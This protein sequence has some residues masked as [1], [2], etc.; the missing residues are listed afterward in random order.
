M[1]KLTRPHE[2]FSGI[3]YGDSRI[4]ARVEQVVEDMTNNPGKAIFSASGSRSQAKGG[5][6]LLANPKF[7]LDKLQEGANQKSIETMS[8][9]SVVLLVQDTMDVNYNTHKKTIGLGY[10]SEKA[11]GVKVHTCLAMS[12]NGVPIGVM[13]QDCFTR[14]TAKNEMGQ[15]EKAARPIEEKES[16]RWL[17]SMRKTTS[18]IPENITAITICDRECDFYEFY[19]EAENIDEKFII[20]I[21]NNRVTESGREV[22][23]VLENTPVYGTVGVNI[24]RD[25]RR[26]IP[27]RTAEMEVTFATVDLKKPAIRKETHISDL[28]TFNV[29]RIVEKNPSKNVQPIEWFLATNLS[30][31]TAEEAFKIVKRYVQRWKIG[32]FHHVLKSG[33]NIE[34]IQQRSYDGIVPML[35][36]YSVI[37]AYILALTIASQ[38]IPD[39]TCDYFFK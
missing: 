37:A 12:E 15:Y 39:A 9:E 25:S 24:P 8:D 16:N 17:E 21:V 2:S 3:E 18:Q 7:T 13:S 14:E 23:S 6:R 35:L 19:D 26:N 30:V 11:L 20:R 36:I 32:R 22:R 29:V 4:N 27:A 31:A 28:V 34:K 33:C 38:E 1:I 10:S 5:Y